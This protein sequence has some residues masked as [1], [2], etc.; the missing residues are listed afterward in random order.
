MPRAVLQQRIH[1]HVIPDEVAILLARRAEARVKFLWHA[2]GGQ[3]ADVG[4][5]K[6]VEREREAA[7]RHLKFGVRNLYMSDHAERVNT[8]VRAAGTMDALHTGEHLAERRLDFF[9]HAGTNFLHLPA[10]ISRAVVRDDE[11]EFERVHKKKLTPGGHG[12]T[13]MR[14]NFDANYAN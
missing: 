13:R 10:L 11:F 6:G 9:L 3:H 5:Q 4:R 2:R 12:S 7:G 8:R 1:R 14:K